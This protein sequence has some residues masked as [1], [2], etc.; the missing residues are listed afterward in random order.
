MRLLLDEHISP[1]VAAGLRRAGHDAVSLVEVGL[2][3]APDE[4]VWRWA[5][6][7]GRAVVS[8][9]AGDFLALAAQALQDGAHHPGQILVST[10]TLATSDIGGLVTS[11]CGLLEIVNSAN[12]QVLYVRRPERR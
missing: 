3:T 12:D 9:N 6:A 5:I 7:E 10:R 11:V 4:A 1:A 2:R 8:Y